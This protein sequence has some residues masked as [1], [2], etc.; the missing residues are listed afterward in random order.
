[1]EQIPDDVL[2]YMRSHFRVCNERVAE[3]LSLYPS[4]YEEHLDMSLIQYWAQRQAPIMF[5]SKWIIKA[6]VNFMGGGRHYGAWEV[7]D[8]GVVLIFRRKGKVIRSKMAFLQC[9]KLYASPLKLKDNRNER[10]GYG[11]GNLLINE[12]EHQEIISKTLY[13]Y[14]EASKFE[15]FKVGS[16]QQAA[17][18]AFQTRYEMKMHYLFYNPLTIPYQVTNPIDFTISQHIQPNDV[19]CRVMRKDDVDEALESYDKGY[20]PTYGDI[21]YMLPNEYNNDHQAGWR[22]EYFIVDL[23]MGCK[24][25]VIDDS[26]TFQTLARFMNLKARPMN[27]SIA[28]TFDIME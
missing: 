6:D 20:S 17:M 1:M 9:K 14:S 5:K 25:G 3:Q 2:E 4:A 10:F 28:F 21:K 7:A 18:K 15:A 22:L 12:G 13:K 16:E 23:M 27:S 26:P 19:G 24:E 11:M 8:I